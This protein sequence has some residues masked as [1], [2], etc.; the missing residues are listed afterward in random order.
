MSVHVPAVAVYGNLNDG[1]TFVGPFNSRDLAAHWGEGREQE[2]WI[3]LMAR[4]TKGP[5]PADP[6]L[7]IWGN[8]SEGYTIDGFFAGFEMAEQYVQEVQESDCDQVS[9]IV[10]LQTPVKQPIEAESQ[11][12]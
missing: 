9:W 12:G 2:S 7:V 11:H 8:F 5:L 1:F 6:H 4:Y 10:P 3:V